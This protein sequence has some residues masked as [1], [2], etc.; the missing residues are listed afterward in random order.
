[1]RAILER[2][3]SMAENSEK[4]ANRNISKMIMVIVIVSFF[5]YIPHTLAKTLDDFQAFDKQILNYINY[6]SLVM[7]YSVKS[8]GV[9][10][11][12]FFNKEYRRIVDRVFHRIFFCFH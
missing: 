4:K 12:Y 7:M 1:M 10:A 6:A 5:G 3:N 9:F 11:F 2:S 8:C